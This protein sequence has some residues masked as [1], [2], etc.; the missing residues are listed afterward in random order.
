MKQSC[1]VQENFMSN[2][3]HI[4]ILII[5]PRFKPQTLFIYKIVREQVCLING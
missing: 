2:Y 1:D 3:L 4:N 5:N